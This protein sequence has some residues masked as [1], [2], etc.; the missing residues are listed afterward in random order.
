MVVSLLLILAGIC[1]GFINTLAG[2]GSAIALSVLFVLGV[3]LNVANGTY[4]VAALAQTLTSACT[5][6]SAGALL[7]AVPAVLGAILGAQ[8]A[9]N[10]SEV[11]FERVAA[12]MMI[13]V[14]FMV[15]F[16]P[17]RRLAESDEPLLGENSVLAYVI[18]FLVGIYGGFIHVGVGYLML[19]SIAVAVGSNLVEANAIKVVIIFLYLIFALGVFVW[20]GMVHYHYAL[21]LA[22]GQMGGA[23]VGAR[24]AIE[25]GSGF[26]RWLI[27]AFI[28][29]MLPHLLGI[30]DV[31]EL[32]RP[33]VEWMTG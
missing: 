8:I 25:K 7:F 2:G 13:G 14:L 23:F 16:Q 22:V 12:V 24:M 15:I 18:F 9:V 6:H 31:V 27:V 11:V 28:L 29:L 21:L 32:M 20:G 1:A 17:H 19:I 5:F 30:V 26:I 4:R 33:A 10:L 3:P